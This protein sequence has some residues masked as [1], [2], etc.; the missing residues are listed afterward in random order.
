MEY[1]M[2]LVTLIIGGGMLTWD[3]IV[4]VRFYIKNKDGE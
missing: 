2:L 3:M 1:V 4:K